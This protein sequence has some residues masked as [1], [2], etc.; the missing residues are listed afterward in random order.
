MPRLPAHYVVAANLF[1]ALAHPARLQILDAL[2][3]GEVCVCHIEAVLDQRQAYVSQHL[4]ALRRLGLLQSRKDGLRVYYRMADQRVWRVLNQVRAL[5]LARPGKVSEAL[6]PRRPCR[7]PQC[8]PGVIG[9]AR[10]A[11]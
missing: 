3:G 1:S 6:R 9:H 8:A 5:T 7:C 11:R 2:R 4:M 10:E